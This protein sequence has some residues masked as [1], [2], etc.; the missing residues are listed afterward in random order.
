ML[1]DDDD[2]YLPHKVSFGVNKMLE[3]NL[4]YY[5]LNQGFYYSMQEKIIDLVSNLFQ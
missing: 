3:Y 2:I 5:N 1:W 4:E